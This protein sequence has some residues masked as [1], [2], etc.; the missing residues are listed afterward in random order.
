MLVFQLNAFILF[1]N[2]N[3]TEYPLKTS[4]S[5]AEYI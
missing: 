4:N 5:L 2:L 3:L 1:I